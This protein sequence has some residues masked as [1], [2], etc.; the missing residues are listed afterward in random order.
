MELRWPRLKCEKICT[1]VFLKLPDLQAPLHASMIKVWP[2]IKKEIRLHVQNY[3][4]L[5]KLLA[6]SLLSNFIT[7]KEKSRLF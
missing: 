2:L 5:T 6:L 1:E 4:D 3:I 7:C